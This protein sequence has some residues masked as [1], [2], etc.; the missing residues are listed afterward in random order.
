MVSLGLNELKK[1]SYKAIKHT[2]SYF[3]LVKVSSLSWSWWNLGIVTAI[4]DYLH[5]Y[6]TIGP[7][8]QK[9]NRLSFILMHWSY[10]CLALNHWHLSSP[11]WLMWWHAHLEHNG[12]TRI[13]AIHNTYTIGHVTLVAIS[14]TTIL[15]PYLKVKSPQLTWRSGTRRLH[16]QVPH[17]EMSCRNLT[18]WE[19]T[20]IVAPEITVKSLI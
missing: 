12:V 19:R 18:T 5:K 10:H 2:G 17:L 7:L 6:T 8:I 4:M 11:K 15:L 3:T 1:F 13:T 16:P 9:D 14:G 20:R